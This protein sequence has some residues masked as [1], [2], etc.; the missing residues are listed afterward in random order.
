MDVSV[1]L[2]DLQCLSCYETDKWKEHKV[3][4]LVTCGRFLGGST[5]VILPFKIF[6]NSSEYNCFFLY[7]LTL[8]RLIPR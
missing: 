7:R 3:S 5:R 8:R 2:L 6:L 4:F 1:C